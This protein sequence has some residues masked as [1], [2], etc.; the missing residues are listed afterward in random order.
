MLETMDN[1]FAKAN[2]VI[3]EI[4]ASTNVV[5]RQIEINKEMVLQS[6]QILSSV[7]DL[8]LTQAISDFTFQ[9][10]A[11]EAAQSSYMQMQGLL[12]P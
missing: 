8:D 10:I 4:G 11:I 6:K 2:H 12:H 5:D 3:A 9:K 1:A 7:E